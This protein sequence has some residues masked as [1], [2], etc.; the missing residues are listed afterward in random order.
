MTSFRVFRYSE[1]MVC[2]LVKS[3]DDISNSSVNIDLQNLNP[4]MYSVNIKAGDSVKVE[5]IVITK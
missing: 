4:G 2:M 5:R 3:L 1:Q